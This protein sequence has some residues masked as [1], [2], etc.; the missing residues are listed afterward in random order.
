MKEQ[1]RTQAAHFQNSSFKHKMKRLRIPRRLVFEKFY[2][3]EKN[4]N[5]RNCR[6]KFIKKLL[7]Q[8]CKEN[9]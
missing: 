5:T 7:S 6:R 1:R 3:H 8:K 2:V 4:L 9:M